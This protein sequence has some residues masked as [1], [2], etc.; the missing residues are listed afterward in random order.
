M[1]DNVSFY[2][3]SFSDR[4][5]AAAGNKGALYFD[6]TNSA[7]T[8]SNGSAWV[9]FG[10]NSVVVKTDTDDGGNPT[11]NPSQGVLYIN[12]FDKTAKVFDG[13]NWQV[14]A[15]AAAT[16]AVATTIGATGSDDNLPTEKAVRDAITAFKDTLISND[17]IKSELIPQYAISEFKGEATTKAAMATTAAAAN[18]EPGD[19]ASVSGSGT[20]AGVY[21]LTATPASTAAN[22]TKITLPTQT[23]ITV[24]STIT[25]NSGNPVSSAA[26]YAALATKAEP[27]TWTEYPLS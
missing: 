23:T 11:A 4:P 6:T 19:F 20:D 15:A 16:K 12:T 25:Q 22:W 1:S 10:K 24:E 18:A 27:L 26:I 14:V 13:S 2:I 17:Q 7:I 5:A 21:I 9:S 3:G 8:R